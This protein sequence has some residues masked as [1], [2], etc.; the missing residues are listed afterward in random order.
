MSDIIIKKVET[1][2][3]MRRFINFHY[4]LYA[5]NKYDVPNLFMDDEQTFS[6]EKN[7]AFEFCEAK[8]FLAMQGRKV[9]GRVAAIINH[10]ANEK[11]EQKNVRFGWIDFINDYS[12]SG[13]LLQAVEEWGRSKGMTHCVGP[14]G[15]TDLDPEGMLTEGFNRLGTMSTIYNY[16]YYPDHMQHHEGYHVDN[17]YVEFHIPVPEKIPEKLVKIGEMIE[18]RYNLHAVKFT[19]QQIFHEGIGETVFHL[20]NDT[21]KD[22]YGYSEL[23]DRQIQQYCHMYLKMLDTEFITAVVDGNRD[24]EI[25]GIGIMMASLSKALQKCHRGSLWPLGWYHILQALYNHKSEGID[26]LLIGV[27]PEYRTKGANALLF[28]DL[29]E[30]AIRHG[31]KWAETNVEMETNKNVQGQWDLFSPELHKRRV[32]WK[33]EL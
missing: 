12:V 29:V 14:L 32:C 22:L 24:N 8:F 23:T 7:A 19:K 17:R 33:K 30:R 16:P 15:F 31:Y 28:T 26:L 6:Q 3:D 4:D 9:V 25:V 18:R 13:A 11:W 21:Y 1:K 10:R 2:S 20:I 27:K 5:G